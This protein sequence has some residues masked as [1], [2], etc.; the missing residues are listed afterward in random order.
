MSRLSRVVRDLEPSGIREFFDLVM[1]MDDVISLGVGEPDFATPWHIREAA[2]KSLEDG[3]TNYTSNQGMPRLRKLLANH[4]EEKHKI[5]YDAGEE[6]L[7]TTGV[8]EG[9]DLAMRALLNPGDEVI[10]PSPCYVSYKP[11]V[12]MPGGRPRFL[13]TSK[14]GNFKINPSRLEDLINENTKILALNYPCNPTGVTYTRNELE[15]IAEIVRREDLLVI[16]DEIYSHLTYGSVHIPFPT[17]EGMKERTVYLNGFSKN[18][19]MTGMRI[20]YAGGPEPIISAMNKIHQYTMLCAP[21]TSQFAAIEAVLAGESSIH[22]M[23]DEYEKRR[24]LVVQ[25]LNEIGLD[26][27]QPAGAFYAFPSIESTGQKPEEFCRKLLEEKKVAVVPGKAFGPGG[28]NHI[29][30][31]YATDYE[32]LQEALER[33]EEFIK[34]STA[35]SVS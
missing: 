35:K 11:T 24:D 26:C 9:M 27:P 31:S 4:L 33:M 34:E 32:L 2:I 5:K 14:N 18:C 30:L 19:A 10:I 20:A 15:K 6:L 3:Y 29:R 21:T 17:L 13:N 12:M 16:T 23:R 25:R 28:E 8:S 1:G 22:S 7:I